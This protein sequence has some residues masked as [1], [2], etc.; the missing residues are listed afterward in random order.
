MPGST[1]GVGKVRAV[2]LGF[3]ARYNFVTGTPWEPREDLRLTVAMIERLLADNPPPG[4]SAA[5]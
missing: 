4:C 2:R 5:T 3:R 1:P